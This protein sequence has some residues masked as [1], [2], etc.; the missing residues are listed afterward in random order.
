[1]NDARLTFLGLGLVAPAVAVILLATVFLHGW[2]GF[3]P[4]VLAVAT[5]L[6]VLLVVL[7]VRGP[8]VTRP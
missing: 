4:L 8:P 6:V 7:F 2:V 5:A 3:V 1:V